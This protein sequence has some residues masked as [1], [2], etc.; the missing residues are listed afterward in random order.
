V[1]AVCQVRG[2]RREY[3]APVENMAHL[4]QP[5]TRLVQAHDFNRLAGFLG[6]FQD[7]RHQAV[8]G[9]DKKVPA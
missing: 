2:D 5:E 3:V 4:R 9:A 7:G 1:N 8:V 6:G